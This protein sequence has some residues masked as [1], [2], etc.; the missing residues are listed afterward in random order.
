MTSFFKSLELLTNTELQ[1]L[2][3]L[4]KP[5]LLKKGDFLVQEGKICDEIVLIKSGILRSFYINNEGEE[6]TNCITFENELM[7]AFA[8]FISQQP[9]E[10]NIQAVADTELLVLKKEDLIFLY[11]GSTAW[12]NVGRFL[13]ELQYVDLEK[14]I[15]SF[16]KQT[17]KQRYETLL[18]N[19]SN[20]IKFIP[21]KY[22]ASYLG[23]TPRHLSRIRKE[24]QL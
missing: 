13:T 7:S 18:K 8:S 17:A 9:S 5:K 21:L 12:Q 16:Q 3:G 14:R 15:V 2:N 19:R 24:I 11:K 23:V 6:F 22:L 10:E 20:Y 4:P 1:K